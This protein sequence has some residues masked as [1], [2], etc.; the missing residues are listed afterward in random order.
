MEN[1][2]YLLLGLIIV[3]LVA[4]IVI[5]IVNHPKKTETVALL[6]QKLD[7][8]SKQT[9]DKL[10]ELSAQMQGLAKE[11]YENRIKLMETLSENADKQTVK[12]GQAITTM[13]ESNEKKLEEMRKTVDE[14]LTDT[15]NKRINSSFETVSKQLE[16]VYKSLGEMKEL[17]S[18]V[19]ENVK[20]LFLQ[21]EKA[22][23]P[24]LRYSLAT[25][26]TRPFPECTKLTQKQTRPITDRLSLP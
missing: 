13:Q 11:N 5:V 26:L 3:L 22:A 8:T 19:T 12:V 9:N 1:I 18:G 21:M 23:A 17:S 6:E 14:K 24:G 16:N 4:L 20:G 7:I 15:L 2:I 25:S 10:S